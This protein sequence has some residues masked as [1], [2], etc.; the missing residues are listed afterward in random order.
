M[1]T[2]YGR[3]KSNKSPKYNLLVNQF[4]IRDT[5]LLMRYVATQCKGV[6][7]ELN[8]LV[9]VDRAQEPCLCHS[10]DIPQFKCTVYDLSHVLG[11]LPE[12]PLIN[13]VGGNT[14][15]HTTTVDA[16]FLMLSNK[17]TN[18]CFLNTHDTYKMCNKDMLLEN[19]D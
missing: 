1:E 2:L 10:K 8:I 5:C 11:S 17:A 3:K 13:V 18:L 4:L 19:R 14:F 7:K 16:N 9:N 12:N 6:F 15:Y